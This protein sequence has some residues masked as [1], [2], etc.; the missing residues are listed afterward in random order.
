MPLTRAALLIPLLA[1]AIAPAAGQQG[2]VQAGQAPAAARQKVDESAL[3]YFA[4]Q[5]DQ[6]RL[7][8]EIARLRALYPD[9]TP[10]TDLSGAGPGVDPAVVRMW[11]MFAQGR[12]AEL[13]R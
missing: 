8:T 13:R 9:W 12:F 6:R 11:A 7:E 1:A 4:A 3:R 10:P 2:P 5:G